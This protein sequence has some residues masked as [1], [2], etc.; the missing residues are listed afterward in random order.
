MCR[1]YST[2]IIR[3]DHQHFGTVLTSTEFYGSWGVFC[4]PFT[5][6]GALIRVQKTKSMSH[7]LQRF[8]VIFHCHLHHIFL[9]VYGQ[10]LHTGVFHFPTACG[11]PIRQRSF[12]FAEVP[13][14]FD[15]LTCD[16]CPT[17][18]QFH[19]MNIFCQLSAVL[20]H[21][22]HFNQSLPTKVFRTGACCQPY[23]ARC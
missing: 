8:V 18:E 7:R 2:K 21:F 22:P 15:E 4:T 17:Y 13:L 19:H 20:Q 14:K 6:F 1:Q 11:A 5:D 10:C 9:E 3:K 23:F 16:L 12:S